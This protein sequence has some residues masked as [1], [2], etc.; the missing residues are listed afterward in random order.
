MQRFFA[1]RRPE[2]RRPSTTAVSGQ[3][4]RTNRSCSCCLECDAR[5]SEV[6]MTAKR[7]KA[8]N[9][10]KPQLVIAG[11]LLNPSFWFVVIVNSI[12]LIDEIW[13]NEITTSCRD[14]TGTVVDV[15]RYP[16]KWPRLLMEIDEHIS[17]ELT[18]FPFKMEVSWNGGTPPL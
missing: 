3:R 9:V 18:P 5:N 16:L 6:V 13:I 8:L 12:F 7:W 14:K 10:G 2:N 11:K 1:R 15:T 17:Q 4:R